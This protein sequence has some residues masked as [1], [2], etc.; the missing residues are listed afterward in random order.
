MTHKFPPQISRAR[1]GEKFLFQFGEGMRLEELPEGTR[2]IYPGVRADGERDPGRIRAWIAQALD[3]PLGAPPLRAKLRQLKERRANPRVVFAFDDVSIPLPPM[4]RP[5][6]RGLVMEQAEALCLE[7]GI[8]DLEFI[9]AIALHRPIRPD[10]FRHLCGRRLFRKYYPRRMRNYNAI[11]PEDSVH[12]G[13]TERGEDVEVCK[14]VARADLTI[15]FNVNY[16]AMDGGY[17]SYATGLVSYQSLRHNHDSKTL[18]HTRSLYDPPR[19]AMHQSFERIGRMIQEKVDIFHIETVLDENLFPW[20][21]S[22]VQKFDRD[23]GAFEKLLM[24]ASVHG[25]KL[26]P[27]ALRLKI[28]W[29]TRGPFGLVAIHAGETWQVH[30]QTLAACYEGKVVEVDG[31]CD[32]LILAPTC[33]GPYTK[34]TYFNPLLVNTYALGYYYNMY[35][36][37]T[38]LVRPGGAV[39]VVNPLP[40]KWTEPAHTLYRELFE[41]VIATHRGL[42][43]FEAFQEDFADD[44]RLNDLYRAGK[45]PAGVHGFYMYT[46]AAHGMDQVSKVFAVGCGGQNRG[47]QILGWECCATIA[48]AVEAARRHLG[49]PDAEATYFRCPPVGYVRVR[50]SR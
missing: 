18:L 3:H 2:I 14:A 13:R 15:Y 23:M 25:L 1:K 31:P 37:G 50:N 29:A 10:E 28:F 48:Q 11:D 32:I 39:I 20:H 33:I 22:W 16:V 35:L 21:L 41:K 49:K 4:K 7:E 45:A 8:E 24:R 38:P 12:L 26:L 19:S 44:Q 6:I 17:K 46:W 5:D 36:D 47:A 30:Q 9:C 27:H 34:D 43:E 42:D 40:Y